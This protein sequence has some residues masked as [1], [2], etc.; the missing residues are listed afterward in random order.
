MKPKVTLDHKIDGLNI[1]HISQMSV[2]ACLPTPNYGLAV[3][4]FR[5]IVLTFPIA[6][7]IFDSHAPHMHVHLK[8]CA[9]Y[10]EN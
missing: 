7:V 9:S 5:P 10:L 6:A 8:S 4:S 1:V 2:L 3:G